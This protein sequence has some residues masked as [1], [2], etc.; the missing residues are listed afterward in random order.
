MTINFGAQRSE[1][2]QILIDGIVTEPSK[3]SKSIGSYTSD[4]HNRGTLSYYL[5]HGKGIANMIGGVAATVLRTVIHIFSTH[6]YDDASMWVQKPA[7]PHK[8]FSNAFQK[9]LQKNLGP[10]GRNVHL[11]VL[12]NCE[13]LYV[14]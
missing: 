11:T 10:K 3:Q 1:K 14:L 13:T 6:I 12:N 7:D 2:N 4:L 9:K 8:E 5:A